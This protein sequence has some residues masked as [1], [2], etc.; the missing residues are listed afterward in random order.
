MSIRFWLSPKGVAA[1]EEKGGKKYILE[2][3]RV[4]D[5]DGIWYT[6]IGGDAIDP[7]MVIPAIPREF[8]RKVTYIE[9]FHSGF[10]TDGL[11][12]HKGATARIETHEVHRG[13]AEITVSRWQTIFVSARSVRTLRQI[14]SMV[15]SGELKP[16]VNWGISQEDVDHRN[17][18]AER[19]LAEEAAQQ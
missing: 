15:R 2:V 9:D 5:V 4:N 3:L 12:R 10:R 18:L 16:D 7:S 8:I 13:H 17:R 19:P 6:D 11:Y 1:I 14:Y